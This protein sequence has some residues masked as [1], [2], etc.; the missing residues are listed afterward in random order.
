MRLQQAFWFALTMAVSLGFAFGASRPALF[1]PLVVHDDVRQH[2]FWAPRLHDPALFAGD[3]IAEYY[4]AQAPAGY[5]AV[6][7]AATLLTDAI[8]V[9][10]L[11]PL[12][13]TVVLAL[14][15]F[16]LA[17]TLWRR[18]DAAAL[19]TVLLV[20]IVWQYDDV[21]SAT[22]RAYALPLLVIQLAALASGR[23]W[24]ALSILPLQA[25]FYPLGCALSAVTI[26]G[27]AIWQATPAR[28]V[29]DWRAAISWGPLVRAWA[30]LLAATALALGLTVWGQLDAASFGR[31]VTGAEARSL[32]EFQQGGRAA[33]FVDDPY[34]FWLESSRSGFALSP[35]DPLLGNLPAMVLPFGLAVAFGGWLLLGRLRLVGRP[36]VPTAGMLLVVVLVASLGLFA[37]AHLLLYRLYLPARHVQF[38]LPLVWSLAGGLCWTLLGERLG[39]GA[40]AVRVAA[41]RLGLTAGQGSALLGIA[42]LALHPPPPGD[43]YVTGRHPAIYAFLR[44][45]PK[46]T[47]VATLPADG[48]NLPLFG[49]RG[50][51]TSFEHLLPYQPGYYEPLRAR[52]E[53]FRTAYYAPTLVP[54]AQV[55]QQYGVGVVIADA[56]LLERRRRSERE[57]PPA[58]EALLD[59]CG[60]LK[61]RE[62]VVVP[63]ACILAAAS[64]P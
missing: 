15:G 45:T 25:V 23:S 22:P 8:W 5:Q 12:V 62:L 14:G 46:E 42:L 49:Q 52:T 35:R 3:W 56:D 64:T 59:R 34:R 1:N 57:R 19:S 29:P 2:V 40:S 17:W 33:Y 60:V 54:L 6:Y 32:P 30:W 11:L 58:L 28:G 26:G 48:S 61:E 44:Q 38:S 16:W 37:A 51:L 43:F 36:A 24:L 18:L 21:A 13:L 10:K 39:E 41:G 47:L 7:W 20:W 63:A 53:A 4:Q 55:I 9:S 27:W 50:V 31:T